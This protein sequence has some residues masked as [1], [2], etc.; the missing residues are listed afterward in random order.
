MN[1]VRNEREPVKLWAP[2]SRVHWH[3]RMDRSYVLTFTVWD[4]LL[5]W[6]FLLFF[7]LQTECLD[8]PTV[9][10]IY[11]SVEGNIRDLT[12]PH[13]WGHR[14]EGVFLVCCWSGPPRWS[15][16]Q[17]EEEARCWV[18]EVDRCRT[19][20]WWLMWTSVPSG[21]IVHG[22]GTRAVPHTETDGRSNCF[23]F[24]RP[25][26]PLIITWMSGCYSSIKDGSN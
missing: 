3:W 17:R 11:V 20:M 22:P 2:R 16:R 15:P 4:Q 24:P 1:R 10:E 25:L 26:S 13:D 19:E 8:I 12:S 23:S 21:H 5:R 18:Q 7:N 14:T 9:S 6:K